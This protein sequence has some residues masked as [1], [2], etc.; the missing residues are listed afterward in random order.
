MT[1][2]LTTRT[3]CAAAVV[4]MGAATFASN[5]AATAASR[6]RPTTTTTTRPT[7][8]PT[9]V[10]PPTSIAAATSFTVTQNTPD[11]FQVQMAPANQLGD[12]ELLSGPNFGAANL[13]SSDFGRL[14]FLGL[15]ENSNYTFRYRNKVFVSST[16]SFVLSPWTTFAFRTPTFDSL[17]PLA[18]PNLRVVERTATTV[19]VRWDSVPNAIRYDYSLNGGT[20]IFSA[21]GCQYCLA[22]DALTATFTRPAAGSTVAFSVTATRQATLPNCSAYCYADERFITSLPS[23]LTVSGS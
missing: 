10:V 16:Q 6:P 12:A 22:V 5:P 21:L 8:P 4:L 9:T 19:T 11:D 17:R 1:R 7:V 18:P 23:L 15:A 3:A 13:F 20:P 14:T 2:S